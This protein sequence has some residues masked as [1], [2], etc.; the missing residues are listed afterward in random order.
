LWI[1]SIVQYC[2]AFFWR[3]TVGFKGNLGN[4]MRLSE[5]DGTS[6]TADQKGIPHHAKDPISM[7]MA[8]KSATPGEA[9]PRI[10]LSRCS[11]A[12]E[13][14]WMIT[15]GVQTESTRSEGQQVIR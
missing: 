14:D 5:S 7:T 6:W 1:W 9:E 8:A 3:L 10:Q 12:E 15:S 13:S 11:R 2:V 4:E